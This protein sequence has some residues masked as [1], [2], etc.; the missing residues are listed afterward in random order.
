MDL[1]SSGGFK[2]SHNNKRD[3]MSNSCERLQGKCHHCGKYGHIDVDY[4]KKHRSPD[5]N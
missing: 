2:D 4:W 5:N 3:R 1:R